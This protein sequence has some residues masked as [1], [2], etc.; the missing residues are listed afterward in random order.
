MNYRSY[1]QAFFLL[2]LFWLLKKLES[3]AVPMLNLYSFAYSADYASLRYDQP[4]IVS[5]S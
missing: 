1:C 2:E 4:R 5:S 3:I